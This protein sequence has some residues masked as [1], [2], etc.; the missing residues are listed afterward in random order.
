MKEEAKEEWE[1]QKEA[2]K[3]KEGDKLEAKKA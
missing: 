3:G 2:E 1:N